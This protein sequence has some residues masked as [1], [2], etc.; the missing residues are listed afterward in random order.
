MANNV[1]A[2]EIIDLEGLQKN[3]SETK[4]AVKDFGSVTQSVLEVLN[5]DAKKVLATLEAIRNNLK[6]TSVSSNGANEGLVNQARQVQQLSGQYSALNATQKTFATTEKHVEDTLKSLDSELAR[7]IK[8]LQ[9]ANT[10]TKKGQTQYRQSAA[11]IKRLE[12]IMSGL[13]AQVNRGKQAAV[14]IENTYKSLQGQTAALKNELKNTAGVWDLTTGKINLHNKAAVEMVR[15]IQLNEAALKR[16]DAQMGNHQRNVGNYESAWKGVTATFGKFMGVIAAVQ[17]TVGMASFIIRDTIAMQRLDLAMKNTSG[18]QAV[19]LQNL[20]FIN[21]TA[22]KYGLDLVSLANGYKILA[23]ATE[24]TAFEGEQ[25]NKIFLSGAQ[26]AAALN[27]SIQDTEGIMRALGQMFSKGTVQSEELKGQL[28]ERLPGAFRRA[29][30]AMGLTTKQLGEQLKLGKITA[31]EMLPRLAK[32]LS[33]TYGKEA[34]KNLETITGSFALLNNEW[35]RFVNSEGTQKGVSFIN[36]SLAETLRIL[37]ELGASEALKYLVLLAGGDVAGTAAISAKA[38]NA[39]TTSAAGVRGNFVGLNAGQRQGEIQKTRSALTEVLTAIKGGNYKDLGY[40]DVKEAKQAATYLAKELKDFK[41][42]DADLKKP[43]S[44]GGGGGAD[45]PSEKDIYKALDAK[46]RLLTSEMQLDLAMNE[47]AYNQKLK[48]EYEFEEAKLKITEKYLDRQ[49][50]IETRYAERIELMKQKVSA[51]GD[52]AKYFMGAIKPVNRIDPKGNSLSELTKGSVLTDDKASDKFFNS[53][54]EMQQ[55][56]VKETLKLLDK[57]YDA[58]REKQEAAF[59]RQQ[60]LFNGLVRIAET[61]GDSIERI[62]QRFTDNRL[63]RLQNQYDYEIELAGDNADAKKKIQ[64]NYEQEEKRIKREAARREKAYAVFKLG[65]EFALQ[66]AAQNYFAAAITGIQ[67]AATLATP[68]PEFKKGKKLGDSYEGPGIFG[69]AGAE[70]MEKDGKRVLADKPTLT[71]V[72]AKTRIYNPEETRR[73]LERGDYENAAYAH[74]AASKTAQ[75]KV[76]LSGAAMMSMAF[77]GAFNSEA[78]ANAIGSKVA[79]AVSGIPSVGRDENGYLES[80]IRRLKQK[81]LNNR[82]VV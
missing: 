33:K 44:T 58:D 41:N 48:S 47:S 21:K 39:A 14:A 49:L 20:Q 31:E 6:N 79:A 53:R 12:S 2:Q 75:E 40:A 50:K 68:I 26:A 9:S 4:A 64:K 81:S 37:N 16:M 57:M 28:G 72:D 3:L 71:H 76:R 78:M 23:G 25:T 66:L 62:D 13:T 43:K 59:K 10:E 11:E 27:L 69:E 73:I 22:D 24:G 1:Q 67:L 38:T 77:R 56:Q 51:Q 19:Y 46:K 7:H 5:G 42:L 45:A 70:I 8:V 18:T 36:R 60:K 32:E 17:A 65:L 35:T 34:Q 63:Q 30:E 52:F 15:Q 54:L 29:A 80:E 82:K 61:V 74:E 55:K